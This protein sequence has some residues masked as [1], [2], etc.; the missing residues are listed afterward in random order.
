MIELVLTI[1]SILHGAQCRDEK[2]LFMADS[3]TPWACMRYGQPAVAEWIAAHPNWGVAKW[4]C[5]PPRDQVGS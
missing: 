1:C 5:R 3:A 2:M 4:T